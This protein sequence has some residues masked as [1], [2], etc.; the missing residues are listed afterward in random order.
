M[1][2]HDRIGEDNIDVGRDSSG[3]YYVESPRRT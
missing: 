2:E 3:C 1:V